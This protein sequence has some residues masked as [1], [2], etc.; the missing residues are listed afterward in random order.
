M[1]SPPKS[2]T[3]SAPT[4][5]WALDETPGWAATLA[6]GRPDPDDRAVLG[7]GVAG[8]DLLDRRGRC[9]RRARPGRA[10]PAATTR[11]I[12]AVASAS[13]CC[14]AAA[15]IETTRATR[16]GTARRGARLTAP[17]GSSRELRDGT[18]REL[19]GDGEEQHAEEA[20]EDV[21]GQRRRDLDADLDA[22]DRR[23]AD[24]EGRRQPQVAVP[25]L[26]PGPDGRGR[27]DGEQRGRRRLDLA[28]AERDERRHEEDPA[29]DAEEARHHAG[30]EAEARSRGRRSSC[31]SVDQPDADRREEHGERE[32]QRPAREPS[33][34]PRCR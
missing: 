32:R 21:L 26:P 16:T 29:A 33:A 5:A 9:Q 15:A 18:P 14:G 8:H 10:G 2:E 17:Q 22:D 30:A 11:E 13:G 12:T 27:H 25:R 34:A 19:R 7:I 4:F 1:I 3:A 28:E 24:D 20:T 31:S 6:I 23:H